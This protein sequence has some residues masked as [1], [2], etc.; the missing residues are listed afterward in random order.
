[1]GKDNEKPRIVVTG[2]A[3]NLGLRLL[4]ILADYEVIGLDLNPPQISHP[5]RF[6]RMDL[7]LEES[8]RE[9][10]L[11]LRETR[12]VAVIHLAFV[13]DP[14][15][16]GVLDLDRMWQINVAGTAR[17]MEAVTEVNR[18][19]AVVGRFIFPSSVSAYGPN[20]PEPV[21][22]DFPLGAHTLP[23]AI[24]KME[25]DKVVQQRAPA[26]RS[27]SVYIAARRCRLVG[28]VEGRDRGQDWIR[29]PRADLLERAKTALTAGP[30]RTREFDAELI[31]MARA[32]HRNL[33]REVRFKYL[34]STVTRREIRVSCPRSCGQP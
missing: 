17:V 23:Y 32:A 26:L 11:L 4:P 9:L 29:L 7:G 6:V 8:C 21:S 18:D 31:W 19:D 16:T 22:E 15:R 5:L 14:V 10:F 3:G 2:I 27:C 28:W 13:L 25:A 24:H 12:P 34:S 30:G 1:M 20:L 33:P